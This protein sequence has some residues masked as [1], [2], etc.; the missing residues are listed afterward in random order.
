[1]ILSLTLVSCDMDSDIKPRNQLN[2]N[3]VSENPDIF[4]TV[5]EDEGYYLCLGT[6]KAPF[7]SGWY[8]TT[9]SGSGSGNDRIS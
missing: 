6:L 2:T 5:L 1:M 8:P 7:P 4:F 3:W 9:R